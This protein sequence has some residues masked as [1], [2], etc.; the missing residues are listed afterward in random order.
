MRRTTADRRVREPMRRIIDRQ[1]DFARHHAVGESDDARFRF[2]LDLDDE[3]RHQPL[4]HQ[5]PVAHGFPHLL[6]RGFYIDLLVDGCHAR[7][8][9]QGRLKSESILFG[10][11]PSVWSSF[12]PSATP[13][14]QRRVAASRGGRLVCLHVCAFVRAVR[15]AKSRACC[16]E[17]L[18]TTRICLLSC[19]GSLGRM[20]TALKASRANRM[21][22]YW[23]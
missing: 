18:K 9:P 13:H 19:G 14:L 17:S 5:L 4:V 20:P 7:I 1:D 2:E 8:Q 11:A 21:G 10:C 12:R 16:V 6:G 22:A 23:A 15:S 3:A